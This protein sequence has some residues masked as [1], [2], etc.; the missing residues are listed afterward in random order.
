MCH[1]NEDPD[2]KA[3]REGMPLR[4]KVGRCYSTFQRGRKSS[5]DYAHW[6]SHQVAF[7]ICVASEDK[8]GR[9]W[10]AGDLRLRSKVW[11]KTI[12]ARHEVVRCQ[13]VTDSTTSA[14]VGF[15][16]LVPDIRPSLINTMRTIQS[17]T[18]SPCP[19]CA[20]VAPAASSSPVALHPRSTRLPSA[21]PHHH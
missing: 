10:T 8:N 21:H 13:S 6:H 18:P 5:G 16:V 3:Q 17:I 9:S 2:F 1:R 7:Q 11:H 15:V 20:E 12:R 14:A 4:R 19:S